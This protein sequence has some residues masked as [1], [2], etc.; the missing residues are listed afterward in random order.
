MRIGALP[1]SPS[2]GP[3]RDG[4]L[5]AVRKLLGRLLCAIEIHDNQI[6]DASFGFGSGGTVQKRQCKRCGMK[7]TRQG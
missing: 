2:N 3:E 5:G 1:E 6:L 4:E 7:T